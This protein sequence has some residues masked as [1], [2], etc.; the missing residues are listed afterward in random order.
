MAILDFGHPEVGLRS[1]KRWAK[2]GEVSGGGLGRSENGP[3]PDVE[4]F[5]GSRAEV[6]GSIIGAGDA[7]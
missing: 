4:P 7:G 6:D 5:G 3:R 2:S 1:E